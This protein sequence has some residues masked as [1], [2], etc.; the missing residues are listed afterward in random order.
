ML[1]VVLGRYVTNS[2]VVDMFK[3]VMQPL[4]EAS[5][6]GAIHADFDFMAVEDGLC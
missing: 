3:D 6:S 4:R 5:D 1:L 2:G